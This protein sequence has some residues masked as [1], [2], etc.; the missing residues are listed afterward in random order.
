MLAIIVGFRTWGNYYNE[1]R[2]LIQCDNSS[3]VSL[4]NTGRCRYNQM[5]S[6]ARNSWMTCAKNNI[7]LKAVHIQGVNYR[8]PDILPRWQ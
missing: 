7:Q 2:I 8:I 6:I 5:L 3:C 4:L 1:K